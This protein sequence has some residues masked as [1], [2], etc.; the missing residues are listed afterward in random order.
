MQNLNTINTNRITPF[1]VGFEELFDKLYDLES[2]SVG[3]PPYNIIKVGENNYLIEM[4]LAGYKKKDIQ[5]EIV[6]GELTISSQKNETFLKES[7]IVHKGIASK[8]FS[9]KFTLSDEIE[10]KHAELNDGMLIVKL[11]RIVPEH[12]KP[13]QIFIK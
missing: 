13:K 10:V 2:S 6:E 5:V 8:S 1:T 11:E 7:E 3:F 4:A 12:K 9:R